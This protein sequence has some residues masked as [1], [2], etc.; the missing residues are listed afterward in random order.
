MGNNTFGKILQ[1]TTFGESHAAAIGGVIDGFPSNVKVDYEL[2]NCEIARRKTANHSFDSQRDEK[3]E[4]VFLSGIFDGKTLGTPIAF[5]V[6]NKDTKS[7]DYEKLKNTFRPSHADFTYQQKYGLRDYRGGGRSS[8][9][10]TLSWVIAG[11]FAKMLL[12]K[13]KINISAYVS[14]IGNISVNKDYTK[15]SLSNTLSSPIYCPDKKASDKMLQL[16]EKIKKEGDTIGGK[17]TCIIKSCPVGI[18][19][20]IFEKLQAQLAKAMLSINAVKG[21]EYGSGFSSIEMKGSE[22][23]DMFE[24]KNG[25]ISTTTNNSGGI[26]GG[27]SNG[28]NIYFSVAFKPV[29]SIRINQETVDADSKPTSIKIDGR[30]DV[31]PVPRAVPVVEAMAALVIADNLLLSGKYN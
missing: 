16:L 21:F 28:M 29:P 2:I 14:Q 10:E 6:Y 23:N 15:L 25:K 18:G 24:S 4:V 12:N 9:R 22:H 26:Q 27:I 3:D 11:A 1:L 13:H 8:A 17:I 31:C 20:P 30:H 19:E 7:N 5:V